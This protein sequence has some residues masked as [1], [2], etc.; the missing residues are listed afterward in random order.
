[1][2]GDGKTTTKVDD[3]KL[4]YPLGG[5]ET[6]SGF[7][8]YGLAMMVETLCGI[9]GDANYAHKIRRWGTTQEDANLGQVFMAIDPKIFAPGFEGRMTDMLQYVRNL[10]PAVSHFV[11]NLN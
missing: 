7:K 2:D 10:E 6:H 4:L 3:V 8:G 1:M 11:V 9:L 5:D